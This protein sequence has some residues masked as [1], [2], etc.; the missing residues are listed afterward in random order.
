[1]GKGYNYNR[2]E[3]GFFYRIKWKVAWWGV[4]PEGVFNLYGGEMGGGAPGDQGMIRRKF[5]NCFSIHQKVA[6]LWGINR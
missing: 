2:T 1:M 6:L 4:A 5:P 3:K